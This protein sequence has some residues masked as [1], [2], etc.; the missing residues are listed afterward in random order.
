MNE[1]DRTTPPQPQEFGGPTLTRTGPVGLGIIGAG[2]ISNQYLANL[3]QY[4][5]VHVLAIGD[6]DTE[7]A[8]SQAAKY[9]VPKSGDPTSVLNNDDAEII[10]NLTIP[11]AHIEVSTAA[12]EAGKHVW[13]E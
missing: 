4:P 3:S 10:I 5:D 6:L 11:S 7:R 12:L 9:S 13:S 1:Y 2:M 8:A